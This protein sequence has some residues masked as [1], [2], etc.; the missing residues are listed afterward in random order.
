[1]TS[2]K[3]LLA[4]ALLATSLAN[5]AAAQDAYP[6]KPV[7][8]IVPAA[9]GGGTDVFVRLLQQKLEQHLG[10][11]VAVINVPGGGT[12]IG[13]RRVKD[14]KPEGYVVL[15]IHVALHTT[16]VLGKADFSW[17][18]F[19]VGCGTT[20]APTT[21]V[22][23]GDSPYET[24]DQLLQAATDKPDELIA[25]ANLGAAN[26]F[27]SLMITNAHGGAR[28]RYVQTGGGAN[29]I[30]AILG[31]HA[32]SGVLTVAEAKPYFDTGELRV[33]T[34][35]A[36]ERHPDMP[37]VPTTVE[38]GYDALFG[39][40]Y[41]WFFPKGTPAARV[42]TF[43]DAMEKTMSEPEVQSAMLE[44]SIQPTFNRG[45]ETVAQ[46]RQQ[47]EMV[48]AAARAAGMLKE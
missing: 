47:Y 6:S 34:V 21:L 38:L 15:P 17:Q 42:A 20:S 18:D 32:V 35:T 43:C 46:I 9:A 27:A 13:N 30:A 4:T 24:L 12:V 28:F 48:V 36:E 45:E 3:A 19:E 7:Q 33:L 29:S 37:D 2:L 44:R 8:I 39:I 23:K 22:V 11:P 16:H 14:A 1:M 40:D 10:S 5:P 31:G 41:W 25:A 26:H